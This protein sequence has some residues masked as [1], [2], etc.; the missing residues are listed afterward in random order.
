MKL[1]G[2]PESHVVLCPRQMP[3]SSHS[4][5][6]IHISKTFFAVLWG[7]AGGVLFITVQHHIFPAAPSKQHTNDALDVLVQRP[8]LNTNHP[9]FLRPA[10]P[11]PSSTHNIPDSQVHIRNPESS[12]KKK[13]TPNNKHPA[14]GSTTRNLHHESRRCTSAISRSHRASPPCAELPF[15][16]QQRERTPQTHHNRST[17]CYCC[18]WGERQQINTN[19]RRRRC[20]KLSSARHSSYAQHVGFSE[21]RGGSRKAVPRPP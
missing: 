21:Q 13:S 9:E 2:I 12:K 15:S 19:T 4:Y 6:C 7:G 5:W 3:S 10:N 14:A 16:K 20:C 11:L 17:L 1:A 8:R 18:A